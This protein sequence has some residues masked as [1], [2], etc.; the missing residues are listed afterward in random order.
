MLNSV[1]RSGVVLLG[2][3]LACVSIAFAAQQNATREVSHTSVTLSGDEATLE[4]EFT[5]G[6]PIQIR[7]E[8]GEILINGGQAATYVRG[9]QFE[10]E[11]RALLRS[12]AEGEL[13]TG[14]SDF[15]ATEFGSQDAAAAT[16]IRSALG[17]AVAGAMIAPAA[18]AAV[19]EATE[20][21][22]ES[23]ATTSP[24][25][26]A[27]VQESSAREIVSGGLV[28]ELSEVGSVGRALGRVGLTPELARVLNGDLVG[29]MRIVI[30]ARQ[31]RLPEGVRLD[32]GLILVQSDAVI[33]GSVAG[34]VIVAEGSLRIAPT[35]AI[36]GDVVAVNASIS[37]EGGAI[38]GALREARGIDRVVVPEAA[39]QRR[40]IDRG[41]SFLDN[42]WSG[43]GSLAKT[44]AFFLLFGFLGALV[45]YFFRGHLEAVSDTVSYSFGRSFLAGLA[46]EVLF[47]PIL[48]VMTVLVLP[49]IAI[50][51]YVVGFFLAALLGYLGV[52]HAAGE[53]LTR[54]R[55]PTW[56]ARMRRANS[57]Y[58]VLNGLGVL[59]AGF[60]GA[61]ISQMF[62]PLLGWA[63][64]LLIA[65]AWILTWVAATAG[66]GGALL[67][68]GGTRRKY[69][70]PLEYPGLPV[71]ST[72]DDLGAYESRVEARRH[73]REER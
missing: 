10:S 4:L 39:V 25:T 62:G 17:G 37:N 43:L 30:D 47:F 67:S 56:G 49:I 33:A 1:S 69:A 20:T 58:Y 53:N 42:V 2:V 14:W 5:D 45:V 27:D 15:A 21:A 16:A 66:L 34:P 65:A 35:A 63:Q 11:W 36:E 24:A 3:F 12:A 50:P 28:V 71:E 68:R 46:A 64:G 40:V 26:R 70:R 22:P 61:A 44:I 7:L 52:A 73:E 32:H 60:A 57:Y 6:E 13:A 23:E 72:L 9:G 59:L 48:L 8:D 38:A 19:Q 18:D 31:Y 51:F 54:H 41:P 29:P 55:F